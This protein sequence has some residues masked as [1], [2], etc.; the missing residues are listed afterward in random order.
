MDKMV[1]YLYVLLSSQSTVFI[2]SQ[3]YKHHCFCVC[4]SSRK[5]FHLPKNVNS[6]FSS[7]HQVNVGLNELLSSFYNTKCNQHTWSNDMRAVWPIHPSIHPFSLVYLTLSL[8]PGYFSRMF[9]AT[10]NAFQLCH[11]DPKELPGQPS[12]VFPPVNPGPTLGPSPRRTFLEHLPF[13]VT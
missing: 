10:S 8:T 3:F 1:M 6:T 13:E 7:L 9:Q 12:Y 2:H 11:W 5:C 4:A